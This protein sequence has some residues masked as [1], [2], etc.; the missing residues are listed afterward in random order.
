MACINPQTNI[1]LSY[2]GKS[3]QVICI[4]QAQVC[5]SWHREHPFQLRRAQLLLLPAA[6]Q[7]NRIKYYCYYRRS[8]LELLPEPQFCVSSYWPLMA[9]A[10]TFCSRNA[11]RGLTSTELCLC[12]VSLPA[13]RPHCRAVIIRLQLQRRT[14]CRRLP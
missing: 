1:P 9:S 6:Y 10:N 4:P 5:C 12:Y 11:Q 14:G 3:N 13:P 8:D 7:Q 2:S